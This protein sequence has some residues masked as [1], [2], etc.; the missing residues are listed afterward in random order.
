M[1]TFLLAFSVV[2]ISVP[3][4]A[5][6]VPN[7]EKLTSYHSR[8]IGPMG[9]VAAVAIYVRNPY[10][11]NMPAEGIA[12]SLS[13]YD[14]ENRLAGTQGSTFDGTYDMMTLPIRGPLYPDMNEPMTWSATITHPGF[15]SYNLSGSF[16]DGAQCGDDSGT[17]NP[18]SGPTIRKW[19]VKKK[20]FKF[21]K[22]GR[23]VAITA[24]RAPGSRIVYSWLVGKKTFKAGT[25]RTLRI[26][27][28][29]V[30]KRVRLKIVVSKNGVSKRKVLRFGRARR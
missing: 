8:L 19:S 18:E 7:E 28:K 17:T 3:A 9:E 30:G 10:T 15:D 13:L 23:K 26:G 29:I 2:G 12:W 22:R 14:C 27:P 5:E 21:A 6:P 24:T 16:N 25:S 4:H 11:G 1:G 20:G